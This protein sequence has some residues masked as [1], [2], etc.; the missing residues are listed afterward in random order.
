MLNTLAC[1]SPDIQSFFLQAS[2]QLRFKKQWHVTFAASA[3]A[4]WHA[5]N[6]RVFNGICWCELKI[7]SYAANLIGLWTTRARKPDVKTDMQ[8]WVRMLED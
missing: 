8:M 4:L 5:R 1:N 2:G 6:D 3:V 7:R